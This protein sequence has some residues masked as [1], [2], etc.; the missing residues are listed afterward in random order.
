M[1][2]S[3]PGPAMLVVPGFLAAF[4]LF[5]WAVTA[6]Q[7]Q[8][9]VKLLIRQLSEIL[10]SSGFPLADGSTV[11]ES[12]NAWFGWARRYPSLRLLHPGA[13]Q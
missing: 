2:G 6:W 12:G 4:Y 8:S 7:T 11:K 5:A 9:A 13:Q 10:G 1:S 3:G